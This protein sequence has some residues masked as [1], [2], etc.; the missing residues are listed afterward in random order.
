MLTWKDGIA[1]AGW[2][3][4]FHAL[5]SAVLVATVLVGH[6]VTCCWEPLDSVGDMLGHVVETSNHPTR[7]HGPKK[8]RV[9]PANTGFPTSR[10][11]PL[12]SRF[13]GNDQQ[14]RYKVSLKGLKS[15]SMLDRRD[16]WESSYP[17]IREF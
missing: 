1:A 4:L 13:R 5:G 8:I 11:Q 12:D 15:I 10:R 2:L 14:N 7:Q 6:G 16:L 17:S 9:I 3:V